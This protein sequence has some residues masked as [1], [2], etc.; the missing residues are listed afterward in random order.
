M[1]WLDKYIEKLVNERMNYVVE[2]Y[3][4]GD[5]EKRVDRMIDD[6]IRDM[7]AYS[8]TEF[9]NKEKRD[10][11]HSADFYAVIA[12]NFNKLQVKDN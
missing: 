8:I 2:N 3:Y 7:V 10:M 9:I 6:K 11:L 12:K 4:S 1:K 5:L